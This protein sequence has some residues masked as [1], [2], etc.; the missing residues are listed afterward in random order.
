[1][2]KPKKDPGYPGTL[3][4][5]VNDGVVH[6]A[7]S[8]DIIFKEGDIV[9]IDCGLIH[10]GLFVDHARTFAVGDIDPA[11]REL[12]RVTEEALR[13]GIEQ[14]RAGNT[15]GDIGY[16]IE[17]YVKNRYGN[18]RTLAGHGVGYA[19]H[20]PPFVPNYGKKGKG[21]PLVPGMVIAIEPM[22]TRG[23]DDVMIADDGY[24]YITTDGSH[25]A[26]FEHTLL[27]TENGP[28][29][30]FTVLEDE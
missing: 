1:M 6:G 22:L 4:I 11:D 12:M 13:V 9:K 10:E 17:S 5:S 7:P 30:I 19:V 27:I 2:L 28:A 24:T 16:A 14:A 29:E 25:A 15:T 8:A 23:T 21:E 26:H 3:C 20:E 18:V